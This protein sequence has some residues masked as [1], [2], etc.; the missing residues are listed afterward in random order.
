MNITQVTSYVFRLKKVQSK[1]VT[2]KSLS[3]YSQLKTAEFNYFFFP[4]LTFYIFD[5]IFDKHKFNV[6]WREIACTNATFTIHFFPQ[7]LWFLLVK[8]NAAWSLFPKWRYYF[9]VELYPLEDVHFQ[10][11]FYEMTFFDTGNPPGVHKDCWCG[12]E[13]EIKAWPGNQ[14]DVL[15]SQ[16]LPLSASY[17]HDNTILVTPGQWQISHFITIYYSIL[18]FNI[19]KTITL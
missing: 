8:L 16:N 2:C 11:T 6:L 5:N 19:F 17:N 18:W 4:V 3:C 13:A 12:S 1:F 10:W 14:A 15:Q 9:E 7:I